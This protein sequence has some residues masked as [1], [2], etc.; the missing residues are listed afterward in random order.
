MRGATTSPGRVRDEPGPVCEHCFIYSFNNGETPRARAESETS[1]DRF[2]T[3]VLINLNS[4]EP[5]RTRDEPSPV[6]EQCF[7]YGFNSGEPA[8]ARAESE[9]SRDRFA[10]NVLITALIAASQDEPGTRRARFSSNVLITAV[11]AA[12]QHEPGPRPGRTGTKMTT[13]CFEVCAVA[14][15]REWISKRN[16]LPRGLRQRRRNKYEK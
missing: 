9:T 11:I 2:A 14:E 15:D 7:N 13:C 16:F 4:G 12:S 5:R 10:S 6:F 8:R 3:N 1:R